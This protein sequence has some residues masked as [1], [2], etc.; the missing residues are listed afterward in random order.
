MKR[1]KITEVLIPLATEFEGFVRKAFPPDRSTMLHMDGVLRRHHFEQACTYFEF[2]HSPEFAQAFR[3]HVE[4]PVVRLR[5]FDY[6]TRLVPWAA[7]DDSARMAY[8]EIVDAFSAG[9]KYLRQLAA[10]I[11]ADRKG[12]NDNTQGPRDHEGLPQ[13]P[14][15]EFVASAPG[16]TDRQR[17][18]ADLAWTHGLTVTEI[19]QR[20]RITRPTVR[21]HLDAARRKIEYGA[22]RNNRQRRAAVTQT[23]D[24]L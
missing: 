2:H 24:K 1:K 7:W 13:K 20:L 6:K 10:M 5:R 15:N 4:T 17:E 12:G 8:D 16:L 14:T 23:A 19:S 22:A 3:S 11:E 18:C 9:V 21:Q